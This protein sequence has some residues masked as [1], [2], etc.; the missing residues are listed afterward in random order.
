[1]TDGIAALVASANRLDLERRR[2]NRVLSYTWRPHGPANEIFMAV[3]VDPC[4]KNS[5]RVNALWQ[6]IA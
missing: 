3:K 4:D 6:P 2:L 5:R 1:V